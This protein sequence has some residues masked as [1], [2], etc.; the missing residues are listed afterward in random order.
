[1]QF[2]FR[3]MLITHQQTLS[4]AA[5][6][7]AA[8][9]D[10]RWRRRTVLVDS[11]V[12]SCGDCKFTK[13]VVDIPNAVLKRLRAQV[14]SRVFLPEPMKGSKSRLMRRRRTSISFSRVLTEVR[15]RP[16]F[17]S[18]RALLIDSLCLL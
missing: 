6:G 17:S 15:S 5:M 16:R 11:T 3:L 9:I 4:G 14:I 8:K 12:A 18:I 13:R 7:E 1:M 10:R 2:H